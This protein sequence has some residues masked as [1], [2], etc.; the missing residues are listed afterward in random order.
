MNILHLDL[1]PEIRG[2]QKQVQYLLEYFSSVSGVNSFLGC[3][4]R[5][6][7]E[8]AVSGE[9]RVFSFPSRQEIDPRNW[10][11][12]FSALK[13]GEIDI[14]HT[15]EPR[16]A[17]LAAFF[18]KFFPV[19]FSLMHTRRVS[20]PL[21][22]RWGRAKYRCADKVV[23][24]S[25]EIAEVISASGVREERIRV[26][27]SAIEV[28]SYPRALRD[29]GSRLR[30]G[31][32]G[33]L[34]AQKGHEFLFRSLSG[35]DLDF[36]LSVIGEGEL[37]PDLIRMARELGLEDRIEF[38]GYV[39][40]A[41]ILPQLDMVVVPSID[42]EG[43]NA[44]IKEAWAAGVPVLVSDLPSNTELVTHEEDGIVFSR[45]NVSGPASGIQRL[46]SDPDLCSSLAENGLKR[47]G[48]FDVPVMG[49]AYMQIYEELCRA[50]KQEEG[51]CPH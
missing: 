47:A 20:Y 14:V 32:I 35:L 23:C 13:K 36:R 2:G 50:K 10:F 4:A 49:R 24:V 22:N 39:R 21:S 43:S 33:A 7:L 6:P 46:R 9:V 40:S 25:R 51:K 15:H 27:P 38:C 41:E 48:D 45:G 5:S 17:S 42:G 19:S 29:S 28:N 1:G 12:L 16:A 37:M 3:L 26:I 11:W 31:I 34:T 18:R 8:R 44:V 30:L